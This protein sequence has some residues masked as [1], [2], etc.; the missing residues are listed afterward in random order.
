MPPFPSFCPGPSTPSSGPAPG[1]FITNT[2]AEPTIIMMAI[3]ALMS[4]FS[5][6]VLFPRYFDF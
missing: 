2:A 5:F 3:M 6:I 4:I 1:L